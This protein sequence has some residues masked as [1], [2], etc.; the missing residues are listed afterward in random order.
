VKRLQFPAEAGGRRAETAGNVCLNRARSLARLFIPLVLVV[1]SPTS[2]CLADGKVFPPVAFPANVTIPDQRALIHFT[3]GTERLVI[4]TRFTGA[5]TNFAWVV[6]LPAQPVIEEATTGLFPTL[7]YLFRPQI[8]HDVTRYFVGILIGTG[9]VLLLCYAARSVILL[10][11]TIFVSFL[12]VS[13]LLPALGKAKALASTASAN[14]VTVLDRR[15][16]GV[17]ETTTIASRDPKALR[18]W[19]RENGFSVSTNSEPV[20]A[21]Y[22]RDGWVFVTAKV[23][24]DHPDTQTSTAHPLSFTFPTTKPVYPMR[25][26][27][28]DNGALQVELYVFAPWRAEARH[29]QV[30]RCTRPAYPAIPKPVPYG[31][32]WSRWSPE[33]PNIVHPLLHQWVNG[34]PVATK[35]TATLTPDQMREDVWLRASDYQEKRN[36]LYSKTAAMTVALN[37]GSGLFAVGLLAAYGICFVR[38]GR[39]EKFGRAVG[40]IAVASLMLSG[41]IYL[42]LPTTQVRLV[43]SPSTGMQNVLRYLSMELWNDQPQS[44]E[45]VRQELRRLLATPSEEHSGVRMA[46][47]FGGT[48]W[49]NLLLG[50]S[51]REEDSPGNF[52]L[53]ENQDELEFL[54]YDALG[55][56]QVLFSYPLRRPN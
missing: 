35:L 9:L 42:A 24:R 15:L 40:L 4:E 6:P 47:H 18:T 36:R 2:H 1:C 31:L 43:K 54:G 12:L 28:V 8:S 29:F 27:G 45:E 44:R 19:L 50:G 46:Q 21:D 10:L 33:T 55:T 3:N 38:L 5:G 34:A 56:P 49:A 13:M 14:A 26:T 53:R 16:V 52:T 25:L 30:E 7:D 48:G 51:I 20:I 41:L 11:A 32:S 39:R 23:N 17:F 22:I 37:W